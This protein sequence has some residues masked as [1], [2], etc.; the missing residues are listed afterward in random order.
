MTSR[1]QVLQRDFGPTSTLSLLKGAVHLEP[2]SFDN[3]R[4]T[5]RNLKSVP[6]ESLTIEISL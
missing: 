3:L 6:L 1:S 2:S 4:M 5:T